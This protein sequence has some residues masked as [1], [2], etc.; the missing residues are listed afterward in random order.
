MKGCLKCCCCALYVTFPPNFK[1]NSIHNGI[2]WNY[3]LLKEWLTQRTR[4]ENRYIIII[5][6]KCN[7]LCYLNRT[8]SKK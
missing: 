4:V 5:T 7:Q 8:Q 6:L 1:S 2:T 3:K